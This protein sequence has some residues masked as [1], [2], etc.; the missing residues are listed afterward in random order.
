MGT[1]RHPR[2]LRAI[3]LCTLMLLALGASADTLVLNDGRKFNGR[4]LEQNDQ[5]ILFEVNRFGATMS[6]RFDRSAIAL[7][8]VPVREGPGLIY[9]PIDGA[10]GM[11]LDAEKVVTA[12]AFAHTLPEAMKERPAY[13]VLVI[14]SPGGSIGD[15]YQIVDQI[16]TLRAQHP[17][18]QTVAYVREALS[19]GAVIAMACETIVMQKGSSIGAAV[20]YKLGPDGTPEVIEEKFQSAFRSDLRNIAER[21]GHE[22]MLLMGMCDATLELHAVQNGKQTRIVERTFGSPNGKLI[23]KPGKVLTLTADEAHQ[24]GLAAGVIDTLDQLPGML[25]LDKSH[26]LSDTP[27]HDL[28]NRNH[29]MQQRVRQQAIEESE[30]VTRLKAI[31]QLGPK[32]IELR[33]KLV[34]IGTLLQMG[35]QQIEQL[36]A[37]KSKLL[38]EAE[39]ARK[40]RRVDAKS[41]QR[42]VNDI[43]TQ[44]KN[45]VGKIED[46]I[47]R[48]TRERKQIETQLAVIAKQINE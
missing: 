41:Y 35:E 5:Q 9:L 14:D 48:L 7:L 2:A 12:E 17:D 3:T 33:A 47:D 21:A 11:M 13:V 27:W 10:I 23:K 8:D 36:D 44:H 20:P 39:S 45:A 30:L 16:E 26:R 19:A 22:P 46:D 40:R 18:I 25:G 43:T 37:Q 15:M 42:Y 6:M 4:V 34:Q 29:A 38:L 1:F 24:Y 28:L 32:V 31:E